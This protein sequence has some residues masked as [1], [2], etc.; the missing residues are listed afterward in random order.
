[1]GRTFALI[2]ASLDE[3]VRGIL[4]PTRIVMLMAQARGAIC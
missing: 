2:R 3:I 4:Q 1:M